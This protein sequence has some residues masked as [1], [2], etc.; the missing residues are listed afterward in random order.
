MVNKGLWESEKQT[1]TRYL[2]DIVTACE[3][4]QLSD[5]DAMNAID[6]KVNEYK[7]IY[8]YA[9]KT[10]ALLNDTKLNSNETLEEEAMKELDKS[11]YKK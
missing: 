11:F 3:L 5:M 2:N 6:E 10:K 4:G 7:K 9:N 8:E 1:L